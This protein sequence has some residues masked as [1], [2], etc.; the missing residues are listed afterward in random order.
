MCVLFLVCIVL[1]TLARVCVCYI[2]DLG[3]FCREIME[4]FM[5]Q[6][7][8]LHTQPE[9]RSPPTHPRVHP[10]V[11]RY[12]IPNGEEDTTTN[13]V[14]RLNLDAHPLSYI[15]DNDIGTAWVSH[16]FTTTED[17]DQGVTLTFDLE[18][19]QYQVRVLH[20]TW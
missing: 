1:M 3:V 10:L 14:L 15:N 5:G 13:R 4:V 18:N 7:P 17:M 12:C 2:D 19:G 8:H 11:E 16:V 9:C 20:S 6:L